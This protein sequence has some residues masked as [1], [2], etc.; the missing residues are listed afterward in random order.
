MAMHPF[1]ERLALLELALGWP[2]DGFALPTAY[3][4]CKEI[5]RP[6]TAYFPAY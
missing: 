2:F 3:N 4:L 6:P 5:L 1:L